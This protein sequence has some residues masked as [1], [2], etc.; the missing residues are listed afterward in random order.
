[1]IRSA[2]FALTGLLASIL[3]AACGSS[4]PL[5]Y[6]TLQ[7][8]AVSASSATAAPGAN[9]VVVR[10]EPVVIPPEL[11]RLELVS[12]GG[13]YRVRIADSDRWA[14]PLDDQIRR[15]LNDD[16]AARLPAHLVAD[17]NEPA[18]KEPRRLLS[19]AII[20]FYAD[21]ECG[22]VLRAD[23]TLHG[24]KDES[25]RGSERLNTHDAVSCGAGTPAGIAAAMSAAVGA[26][27]ERLAAVILAEPVPA[28]TAESSPH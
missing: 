21:D 3:L 26:F 27:S 28:T 22:A 20:E 23:W 8:V 7:P 1:M 17:P 4:P 13:P 11:D 19:V 15:T 24:P 5:R 6:Y 14:A 9:P 12:R 2:H 16:L 25:Q 18:S 10:I